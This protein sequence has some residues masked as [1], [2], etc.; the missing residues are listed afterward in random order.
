MLGD[1]DKIRDNFFD[2]MSVLIGQFAGPGGYPK[3]LVSEL[4]KSGVKNLTII[5]NTAGGDGLVEPF[6]DHRVLFHNHQ[7]KKVI[8][9]FPAPINR[10]TEAKRQVAA[11]TVE[12]E[13]L[14]Q[15]NLAE[16]IRA[17][18]CGIPA[19]YTPVGVGTP[20]ESDETR[21]FHG[22]KYMLQRSL[23]ADIALIRAH[24]S[25]TNNNLIYKGSGRHFNPIMAMAADKVYAE[26][27]EVIDEIDPEVVVTPGIFI[28]LVVVSYG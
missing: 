2:G 5:A 12:I 4:A 1:I 18:G 26:V 8:C 22:K 16:R 11:G 27:D 20:F 28:E 24:K 17:G 15:G 13:I 19:F 10:D 9:S 7:V 6:A 21:V 3:R 14:P 25:D 23:R